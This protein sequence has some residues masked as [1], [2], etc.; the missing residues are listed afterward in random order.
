MK[1]V[2]D[3]LQQEYAGRVAFEVYEDVDADDEGSGLAAAHGVRAVP[4]MMLVSPDGTEVERWVGARPAD[5]L[6]RAFDAA[7]GGG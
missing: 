4:T 2:V 5:E 1:P 3:G 7:V 6:R